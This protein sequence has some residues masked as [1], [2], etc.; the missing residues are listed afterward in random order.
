MTDPIKPPPRKDPQARIKT[1]LVPPVPRSRAALQMSAAASRAELY[2]Q[3]C[4]ACSGVHYP[5]RDAC[6]TCL[7]TDLQWRPVAPEGRVIA[8][9]AIHATTD[10]YFRERLPWRVG[11]VQMRAGPVL[12]AHL[13]GEVATDDSV[14]LRALLDKSGNAVLIALPLKGTATMADDP[15]LRELTASPKHRRVLVT[16]ARSATG[17]AVARALGEAG[18]SEIYLGVAAPWLPFEGQET[19][20]RISGAEVV[21]LDLTDTQSVRDLAAEF[22]GKTDIIVN[23]ADHVRAGGVISRGEVTT[24]RDEFEVNVFGLQRLAQHFG[25]SMVARGADGVRSATAFVDVLSVHALANWAE[26]GA[27]AASA[28]ARHSVLQCLRGEMRAG[29]IRVM[30]IFTGPVDDVWRQPLPPPKVA[31]E[32]IARAVVSA[33]ETGTEESFVGDIA[34]DV[35]ARWQ[36]SPKVLERELQG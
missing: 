12:V 24:S 13:H 7:S 18:A 15:L 10:P 35:L 30:S 32:A 5:A 25:P 2:L 31:P 11:T 26:F 33:L 19:L 16:D 20:C 8:S 22:G 34:K 17:Q 21:P 14:G 36:D 4:R 29:G 27:Y 23:T 3:I 1:A 28:A 6:P 9:T